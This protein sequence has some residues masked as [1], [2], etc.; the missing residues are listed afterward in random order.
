MSCLYG[1]SRAG[2]LRV[3][4]EPGFARTD[5]QGGFFLKQE[6]KF[7][8]ESPN[9]HESLDSKKK[10]IKKEKINVSKKKKKQIYFVYF[11]LLFSQRS[12][13]PNIHV[14]EIASFR[15]IEADLRAR[16]RRK[17]REAFG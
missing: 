14:W 2:S 15:G 1:G 3:A 5:P 7:W 11:G 16:G 12:V 4:E 6:R 9:T 10:K 8:L 13:G 17:W